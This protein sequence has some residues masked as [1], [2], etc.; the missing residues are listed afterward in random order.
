MPQILAIQTDLR[1]DSKCLFMKA[2]FKGLRAWLMANATILCLYLVFEFW[3]LDPRPE[4][5]AFNGITEKFL[6]CVVALP[7]LV[8]SL[9][10]NIFALI[11]VL[12]RVLFEKRWASL[13]LWLL[14]CVAWVGA[15][16]LNGTALQMLS[17]LTQRSNG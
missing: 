3:L 17:L 10:I 5:E 1:L 8:I 16:F 15:L 11:L 4:S 14:V 12:K 2:A 9:G 6:W 13:M 7:L